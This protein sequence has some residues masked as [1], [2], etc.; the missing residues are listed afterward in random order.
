MILEGVRGFHN[1]R[2]IFSSAFFVPAF[3]GS[4]TRGD[5][6]RGDGTR[7]DGTR[8]DGT[9]GDGTR[10]DGTRGDG[11]RGSRNRKVGQHFSRHVSARIWIVPPNSDEARAESSGADGSFSAISFG[12]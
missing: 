1:I 5:G 12:H 10:G 6:T 3:F 2:R 11:T 9:R 8:G 4:G 7:G